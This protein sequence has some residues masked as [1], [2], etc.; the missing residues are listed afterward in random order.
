MRRP[1]DL[2]P[3]EAASDAAL[4]ARPGR[5]Q[6]IADLFRQHNRDLVRFLRARLHDAGD[7]HEVAQESY[8]R[9]LQ[10][11]DTQTI[12]FLRAY[13]FRIAANLATDRL[14]R[15]RSAP[16][17]ESAD[18]TLETLCDPIE[19]ERSVLSQE[20]LTLLFT[21]LEE[22]PPRCRQAFVMHRL[23]RLTSQEVAEQL[24]I[25]TRMVRKHLE[26]ALIYCRFRLDGLSPDEAKARM[27]HEQQ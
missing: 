26:R 27:A 3:P 15:R 21:C 9:L 23:N 2:A 20:Q 16:R 11:Q 25:S 8:V 1:D 4:Q 12:G 5:T 19:P 14:R 24:D 6:R 10:L 18:D 13:L 17:A 7:A 22:L